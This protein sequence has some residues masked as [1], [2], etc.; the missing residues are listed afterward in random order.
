MDCK[1]NSYHTKRPKPDENAYVFC[2]YNNETTCYGPTVIIGMIVE[3]KHENYPD[4]L[5]EDEEYEDWNEMQTMTTQGFL[6]L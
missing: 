5:P 3:G 1:I 6:K 2:E 4:S